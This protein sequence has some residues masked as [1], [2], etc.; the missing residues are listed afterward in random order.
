MGKITF[1][2]LGKNGVT[3]NFILTLQNHFK[4]NKIVRIKVLKSACRNKKELEKFKNNL[5]EKFRGNF[6][7]KIIGYVIVLR[8][9][10]KSQNL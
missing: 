9:F 1:C 4:K 5:L 2:Q 10:G 8:K 7:A 3:D 6:R